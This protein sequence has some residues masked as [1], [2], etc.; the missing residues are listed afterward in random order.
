MGK[1]I[2]KTFSKGVE[3]LVWENENKNGEKTLTVSFQETYIDKQGI[4]QK[5]ETFCMEKIALLIASL[6]EIYTEFNVLK[7]DKRV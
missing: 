2:Y 7:Y 3:V 4:R 5:K 1:L 6:Q